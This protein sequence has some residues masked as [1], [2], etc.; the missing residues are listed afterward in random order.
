MAVSIEELSCLDCTIWL[1]SQSKASDFLRVSQ[2][3][4]SRNI[5]KVSDTF[6]I[7]YFKDDGE[8]E[9]IH[10]QASTRLD[11][12]RKMHQEMRF[13]DKKL[14]LRF[15]A[16]KR[17]K[18]H[19]TENVIK[20]PWRI[21]I[22][23]DIENPTLFKNLMDSSIID[24][25]MSV[26]PETTSDNSTYTA[27]PVSRYVAYIGATKNHPI[28]S[29]SNEI[30]IKDTWN[31]PLY[32]GS[33]EDFPI[34]F[35]KLESCGF[36]LHRGKRMNRLVYLAGL[37]TSKNYLFPISPGSGTQFERELVALPVKIPI[38]FESRLV[39]KTQFLNS[40][41]LDLLLENIKTSHQ[42]MSAKYPGWIASLL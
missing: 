36:K 10:D 28:L 41:K 6:N 14:I 12:Q 33:P 37:L 32:F 27:I 26:W 34:L 20:T 11:V 42:N 24:A 15:D 4:V 30:S 29:L 1:K 39:I 9:I 16:F 17:M 21:G 35:Q 23:S 18:S 40:F 3:V 2:P 25:W 5:K 13:E 31:Y 7:S 8:Y 38:E 19:L 22:S